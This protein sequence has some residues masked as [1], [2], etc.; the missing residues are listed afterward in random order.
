MNQAT[1]RPRL[2]IV[3]PDAAL[4]GGHLMNFRLAAM[5]ATRGWRV[6]IAMLFNRQRNGF[7]RE[8]FPAVT[9]IFLNGDSVAGRL[10][11]PFRL[12]RL[13]KNYSIVMAGLDL[14]AT[15]Y[16]FL[17]STIAR[18]PFLAWM[19]IA[20]NEHMQTT[21]WLDRKLSLTIYRRIRH[22]V[23]PSAGAR[24][25]LEKAVGKK[26]RSAV[27]DIIE[28]FN[29]Q[30]QPITAIDASL[31]E[32]VFELPVVLSI[33]RLAPQKM[34]GRLVRAHAELK[35]QG[36]RHHLVILGEGP[37][38]EQ[39][40]ADIMRLQA[41]ETVFLPGHVLNPDA[42]L[43]RATVFALCSD[44]EGL[45]L[46]LIE[47]LQEGLPIVS[48]DCPAGPRE[49]LQDGAAGLLTPKGDESAFQSALARLL[50]SPKLRAE[51]AQL[52]RDRG[53]FY[54]ADRVVPLWEALLTQIENTH[55]G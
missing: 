16:G 24:S 17:A 46:V 18:K 35:K 14:A 11:L 31:P 54:S 34:F 10:L 29:S 25:S 6:D 13:A 55:V 12:A 41:T 4:G 9:Q 38:R 52:G 5:L 43:R 28:N 26:P 30:T 36:L 53:K 48:M 27:W 47:A 3:L 15:N 45:P 2:L 37:Q 8:A 1:R 40:E 21:S 39:L 51:Y 22:I 20:F 50:Q 42:W 49:I 32:N 19:H 44:Y 7:Y 23:F 33:G